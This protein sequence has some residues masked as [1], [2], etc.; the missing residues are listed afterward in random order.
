MS[1]RITR[2]CL[3]GEALKLFEDRLALIHEKEAEITMRDMKEN[4][5]AEAKRRPGDVTLTGAENG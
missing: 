3:R 1:G 4:Q 5:E 2:T